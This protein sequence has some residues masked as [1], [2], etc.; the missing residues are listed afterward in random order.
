MK[1]ETLQAALELARTGKRVLLAFPTSDKMVKLYDSARMMVH[2]KE[3]AT[4]VV[5]ESK[6]RILCQ[7]R[8][9]GFIDFCVIRPNESEDPRLRG[10][11]YDAGNGVALDSWIGRWIGRKEAGEPV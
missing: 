3:F 8:K 11:E 9:D 7:D 1:V 10:I 5:N 4:L 2:K 6:R